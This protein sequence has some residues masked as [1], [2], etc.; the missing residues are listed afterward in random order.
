VRRYINFTI[1]YVCPVLLGIMS[2]LIII[3]KFWGLSALW[4]L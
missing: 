3:D 1:L 4:N 2:I